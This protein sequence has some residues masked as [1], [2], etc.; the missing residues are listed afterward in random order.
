M[1]SRK[2]TKYAGVQARE[3]SERRYKGRPDICF[4]I[5]YRDA[6][7]KRVRKDVGWASEGFSAALAA[8]MRSR[9]VNEAKTAAAMGVI[10][11]PRASALTFGQAWERYLADWLEASGKNSAPDKSRIRGSL[12]SFCPLPLHQITAHRL[13]QLMGDM[14]AAGKS[15]QT[16]RHAVGLVRRIMRRMTIWKLYA[17][18]LPFDG[19]IM[20]KTNNAR[21]RFLT[22][23]EARALLDELRRRS[24]QT[25]LM[26]LVSLHCGLRFGEVARLRWGDARFENRT[27]YVAESKSGRARHAVMTDEVADAL[28]ALPRGP[29]TGLLFPARDG[30]V[31]KAVSE[32]FN[33][34]VD[35][36]GLN[37]T[38]EVSTGPNGKPIRL[39]IRDRRQRIVFHSLR[40]T[41]ASWLACGGQGQLAIADRLGH[42]SLEMTKRYT[43]LMDATRGMTAQTISAAFHEGAPESP[44]CPRSKPD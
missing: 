35:A 22:P 38:G 30:G 5:D 21:E 34:A 14:R 43:H 44:E 27:L 1:G 15:A 18:P 4:T 20:P 19:L 36:L 33:R 16:I 41:Y 11:M 31:M 7:G 39:K 8:E 23:R 17:G 12:K 25:W 28:S 32:S 3:S 2:S 29:L 10:P 6:S 9:L 26:A 40:H 24:R 13:D 42:H 37:D